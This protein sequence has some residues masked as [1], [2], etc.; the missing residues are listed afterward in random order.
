MEVCNKEL[1]G[2]NG[3]TK[4]KPYSLCKKSLGI[5]SC[6]WGGNA[7]MQDTICIVLLESDLSHFPHRNAVSLIEEGTEEEPWPR[8]QV[9][10]KCHIG[11]YVEKRT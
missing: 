2:K 11:R 3:V 7:Y 5:C 1:Y 6:T 4:R 9:A 10:R 8:I